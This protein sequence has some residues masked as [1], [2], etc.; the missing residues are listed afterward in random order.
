M[1]QPPRPAVFLDRDGVILE[2]RDD[3]VKSVDE[4]VFLPGAFD[5]LAVLAATPLRIV[6][7]TNQALVGRGIIPLA[8]AAAI[9]DWMLAEVIRHGGRIDQ[10]RMCPH[11]PREGCAC[12]KPQPGM[13]RDAAGELNINLSRSVMIGDAVTDLLA[14]QAAGARPV[15][16]RTGRGSQEAERLHAHG[17]AGVA[18]FPSLAEAAAAIVRG[19][20]VGDVIRNA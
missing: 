12:R 16:V 17:L 4:A 5:G 1:T 8:E 2:H 13:L 7:A 3:Y 6:V 11:H 9:N 20:L 18:V 15:L 19:E 14:G 10:I